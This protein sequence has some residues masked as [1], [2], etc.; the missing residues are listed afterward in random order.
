MTTLIITQSGESRTL[1]VNTGVGPAGANGSDG[2]DASVTTANVRAADAL[3]DDEVTNLAAVK[4]F[5]PSDY[6]P[7]GSAATALESAQMQIS[8]VDNGL[9]L[10]T[11]NRQNA[12]TA[13]S[14]NVSANTAN[15]ATLFSDKEDTANKST[16]ITTDQAS[17]T[18]FPSVKAVYDFVQDEISGV[19]TSPGLF[20]TN[21]G[22]QIYMAASADLDSNALT[23]INA[24]GKTGADAFVIDDVVKM[25]KGSASS[26][27]RRGSTWTTLS[28][29]R[30]TN[31][32]G[33]YLMQ[34]AYNHGTSTI[35]RDLKAAMN[36]TIA[37]GM[38]WNSAGFTFDGVDDKLV[39]TGAHITSGQWSC[40]V[41]G[42]MTGASNAAAV[43]QNNSAN[44]RTSF[45]L[46]TP[47]TA[48]VFKRVDPT[49]YSTFTT[50]SSTVKN[51]FLIVQTAT[52]L[53]AFAGGS[54]TA[55]GSTP[56]A[57]TTIESSVFTIGD[58]QAGNSRFTGDMQIAI[59]WS[60]DVSADYSE[61]HANLNALLGLGL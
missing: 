7:A 47:T 16:S 50:T 34:S 45:S 10:E 48:G 35:V 33:I 26:T 15:I 8:A 17:D 20:I 42:K 23:Y 38:A 21:N 59:L 9:T 28:A 25:L 51:S 5:D 57:A 4:A 27:S 14:V 44:F 13:L 55:E 32:K 56:L 19:T 6:D 2:S 36:L 60:E 39:G 3:M 37:G 54:E 1:T 11:T 24:T 12:D 41:V 58:I 49:S 53:K 52:D 31:A 29:N 18:K 22:G 61:I 43:S 40:M 46:F 30:W